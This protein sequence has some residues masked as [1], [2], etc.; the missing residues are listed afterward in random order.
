MTTVHYCTTCVTDAE[1]FATLEFPACVA[2]IFHEPAARTDS[3]FASAPETLS[4]RSRLSGVP[5][6]GWRSQQLQ[7]SWKRDF[8]VCVEAVAGEQAKTPSFLASAL[9]AAKLRR[10]DDKG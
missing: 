8:A 6:N 7:V 10:Q 1:L 9:R 2:V 5:N 4:R 3:D